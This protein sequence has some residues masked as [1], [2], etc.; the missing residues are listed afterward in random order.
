MIETVPEPR[1]LTTRYQMDDAVRAWRRA[2]HGPGAVTVVDPNGVPSLVLRA[3]NSAGIEL[4]EQHEPADALAR[5]AHAVPQAVVLSAE[6]ALDESAPVVTVLRERYRLPVLLAL[7]VGDVERAT[8][9]IVAGALPVLDLPLRPAALLR[10]LERVWVERPTFHAEPT[11]D[12]ARNW[13]QGLIDTL[14]LTAAEIA[15]LSRLAASRG[16]TVRRDQLRRL[17]PEVR[18][19]DGTLV[20]AIVRLRRK[21][22]AIGVTDTIQTVRRIGYRLDVPTAHPPTCPTGAAGARTLLG[23]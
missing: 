8:P 12:P 2:G 23:A 19:P 17:W 16:R 10:Q 21:L 18:D 22:S 3:L 1:G 6:A 14:D 11:S 5:C 15:L 13:I 20:A 7:G 9:A 4:D